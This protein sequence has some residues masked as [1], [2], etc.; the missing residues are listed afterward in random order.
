MSE[1]KIRFYNCIPILTTLCILP[2][3]TRLH[4]YKENM[5]EY[6]WYGM[7]EECTDFF[8]YG[9]AVLFCVV[10]LY[11]LIKLIW[12][13]LQG[14]L[15]IS[16][17]K[18]VYLFAG[19]A[20]C[21]M[22][23]TLCA[24]KIQLALWGGYQRFEGFFV[25]L[26][27]LITMVYSY[28]FINDAESRNIILNG[29]A[30]TAG[31]LCIIGFFQIAGKDPVFFRCV[32]DWIVPASLQDVVLDSRVKQSTV[33]LT[34]ANANNASMYLAG[35]L[36]LFLIYAGVSKGKKK[37][38]L[39]VLSVSMFVCLIFTYSRVGIVML[40]IVTLFAAWIYRHIWRKKWKK[41]VIYMIGVV[42]AFILIDGITG[43]RFGRRII[44]T[45]QSFTEQRKNCDLEELRTG[46]DGIYFSLYGVSV[47]M[48]AK[49]GLEDENT[50]QFYLNNGTNISDCYNE[51]TGEMSYHGLEKVSIFVNEVEGEPMLFL[52]VGET[53]FRFVKDRD[54]GYLLYTGNGK[55]DAIQPVQQ[56][57]FHGIEHIASG[58]FYVWFHAIP[59]LKKYGLFGCGADN[60]YLTYLQNDYLGKAQYCNTPLTIIEKPHNTY[61]LVAVQNGIPALLLLLALYV[62]Y[63]KETLKTYSGKTYY[64]SQEWIGMG[65]F[66]FSIA[67]MFGY[68]FVD[69]SVNISPVFWV[70]IGMGK[71]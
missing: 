8:S 68:M 41:Y 51:E 53:I 49:K 21:F 50:L 10:I 11:M 42:I 70:L 48:Y 19:I 13:I 12:E 40:I 60:F 14:R 69:S 61:L 16:K 7:E 20:I 29:L 55:Y 3:V 47:Q 67:Y 52:G 6:S 30:V 63:F 59:M 58:R 32:Q 23:S 9:K 5:E 25:L 45:A 26:G 44:L 33:Y 2:F 62:L 64:S 65:I 34:L 31:L 57:G 56:I 36:P 38:G 18:E 46:R 66:L 22:I 43:F 1:K 17:N 27:Y 39:Y 4:L 24:E 28:Y 37:I 15:K 35:L 54:Y 71:S